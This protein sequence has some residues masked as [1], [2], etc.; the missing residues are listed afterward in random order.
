MS[1]GINR[2]IYALKTFPIISPRFLLQFPR[3]YLHVRSLLLNSQK[4]ASQAIPI[5]SKKALPVYLQYQGKPKFTGSS[6]GQSAL[7]MKKATLKHKPKLLRSSSVFLLGVEQ[8]L[9]W[10]PI[11]ENVFLE[12]QTLSDFWEA[13]KEK[14]Q[15]SVQLKTINVT[16]EW[17]WRQKG[18]LKLREHALKNKTEGRCLGPAGNILSTHI[19]YTDSTQALA[20]WLQSRLMQT[21]RSNADGSGNWIPR[22]PHGRPGL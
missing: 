17:Y 20:P 11:K 4:S 14:I 3:L 5:F 16:M 6:A 19:E 7:I 12:G 8:R 10:N 9:N 15:T 21:L 13:A 22:H 18:L 2:W 1:E